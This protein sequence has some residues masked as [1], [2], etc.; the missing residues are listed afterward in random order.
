M[1]IHLSSLAA[2]L[3]PH[4]RVHVDRSGSGRIQGVS[5]LTTGPAHGHGFSIDTQTICQVVELGNGIRGHWTHGKP[6]H[7]SL[8]RHL[9]EWSQLRAEPFQVCRPCRREVPESLCASCGA[10]TETAW[11]ALG[12]FAFS[13][14]AWSLKPDG[15]DVPA[16]EYLMA[17]AEEDPQSLG[18]SIVA[19]LSYEEHAPGARV[20]RI[21][22]RQLLRADWVGAPAANPTGLEVHEPWAPRSEALDTLVALEGKERARLRVFAYLARYFGDSSEEDAPPQAAP[23][24]GAPTPGVEDAP[25]V[26]ALQAQLQALA[27]QVTVLREERHEDAL[28]TLRRRAAEAGAPLT[29]ADLAAVEGLLSSGADDAATLLGDALLQRAAQQAQPAF[30]PTGVTALALPPLTSASTPEGSRAAQAAVLKASPLPVF[31]AQTP[32]EVT[33]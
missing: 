29:A 13:P 11:R 28:Q 8:S 25:A 5:V 14:S 21:R 4:P 9:G 1:P 32:K 26:R 6:A 19:E 10:P 3:R 24:H 15:L 22:D 16:P 2:T 31:A 33:S 27:R 20:A 18:V 12:D 17:R 7:D 23:P 30:D